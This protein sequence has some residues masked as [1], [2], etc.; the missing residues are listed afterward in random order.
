MKKCLFFLISSFLLNFSAFSQASIALVGGIHTSSVIEK[1]DLPGFEEFKKGYSNRTG[2]HFGIIA[3]LPIN[4]SARF[5]FQPGIIFQNKGRK[6]FNIDTSTSPVQSLTYNQLINYVDLPLNLVVKFPLSAKTKFIIG[7]GPYLSAFYNGKETTET[8][9][10]NGDF[11][12]DKNEDLPVG[13]A[14]GKYAVFNYGVGALAGLEIGRVMLTANASQGLNDFYRSPDHDGSFKHR[15]IGATLGIFLGQKPLPPAPKDRDKDGIPDIDD[16]CPEEPGSLITNGCPDK[17]GDGIADK[18]DKCPD[19]PGTK[20]YFGCPVPDTD[21]DGINDE[22]DKCPDTPGLTKYNGCPIP[23]TDK[24]GINDELDECPE[25]TGFAKYNGCPVPDSDKDGINDLEDNCPQV[26][27]IKENNGCP[28][29]AKEITQKVDKA[30]R[31]I[32][33]TVNKAELTTASYKVLDEVIRV[34]NQDKSLKLTIEGHTS[35]DGNILTNQILSEQRAN[36]VKTYLI[37]KNIDP[38]R[39]T[40]IGYGASKPLNEGKTSAE[41]NQNRRVELKLSN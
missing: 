6:Y 41:R 9:Y 29:I 12:E 3:D 7:A 33:F 10:K 24:D 21:N 19:E 13:N 40:T 22:L 11:V 28:P 15:V 38:Q 26:A 34:L 2:G 8:F 1:N 25:I 17:D 36:A 35:A 16:A 32:Q 14:E 23:D 4:G 5:S 30:A 27:G 37:S 18:E 39:L 20:K 31:Q